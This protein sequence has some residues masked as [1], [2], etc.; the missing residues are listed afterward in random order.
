V[1]TR[2]ADPETVYV[3]VPARAIGPVPAEQRLENQT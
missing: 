2:D 3:G 1:L